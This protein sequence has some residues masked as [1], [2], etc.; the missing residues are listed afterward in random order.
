MDEGWR[1]ERSKK[2]ATEANSAAADEEVWPWELYACK[3][4]PVV[5]KSATDREAKT[6]WTPSWTAGTSKVSWM[7]AYPWA[8]WMLGPEDCKKVDCSTGSDTAG[9]CDDVE[10]GLCAG[11]ANEPKFGSNGCN[12]LVTS[13]VTADPLPVKVK[14][15]A[16]LD[17]LLLLQVVA[18]LRMTTKLCLLTRCGGEETKASKAWAD[19]HFDRCERRGGIYREQGNNNKYLE[20]TL[21]IRNTVSNIFSNRHGWHSVATRASD[22]S[23]KGSNSN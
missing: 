22:Q 19:G 4:V 1:L 20:L 14:R 3:L 7:A 5:W 21:K 17:L 8:C 16:G 13:S 23:N 18:G 2:E 12:R 11:W 6:D 10:G 15:Q 9:A